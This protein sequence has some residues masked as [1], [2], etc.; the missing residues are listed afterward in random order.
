M[1]APTSSRKASL[2]AAGLLASASLLT[3]HLE[4]CDGIFLEC[5]GPNIFISQGAD[6]RPLQIC[7]DP[8]LLTLEHFV[9]SYSDAVAALPAE[10]L[11]PLGLLSLSSDVDSNSALLTQ[12]FTERM[13]ES[14]LSTC[15][16]DTDFTDSREK[17]NPTNI[18]Y[19]FYCVL[20]LTDPS[21]LSGETR[22]AA[23]APSDTDHSFNL[24]HS[25]LHRLEASDPITAVW[26]SCQ[27]LYSRC[28]FM[29]DVDQDGSPL[30]TDCD[31]RDATR[32]PEA[33]ELCNGL[34]EDCNDLVPPE[35]LDTD[36]DGLTSCAGDCDDSNSQI[37]PTAEDICDGMDNDCSGDADEGLDVR[38]SANQQ[39]S[40]AGNREICKGGEGWQ[41]LEGNYE[42]I[43]ESCND[44]DD[45][46]AEGVDDG[47][48][49]IPDDLLLGECANNTQYCAG[50]LGYQPSPTNY[51]P[52]FE[53]CNGLDDDC[54]DLV[55]LNELDDDG[56]GEQPCAGD[57]DDLEALVNSF[58]A[59]ICDA[60]DNDCD[61]EEDDGMEPVLS[62]NQQGLCS[63]NMD[64]CTGPSGYQPASSNYL[65]QPEVCDG[66]DNNCDGLVDEG[67][68]EIPDLNILGE[69]ANNTLYCAG[70]LGYQPSATNVVLQ[71]ETC[72][73]LDTNCDGDIDEG[74]GEIPDLNLFGRCANNTL[75][76]AGTLGYQPSP[77]NWTPITE[78]C[79][80]LDDDCDGVVPSD[81]PDA[82]GDSQAACDGDCDD[83]DASR[84]S[85]YVEICD[86]ID[87]DCDTL[88]D[89]GM[90]PQPALNIEGL[91]TGNQLI[92]QG[93]SG[94]VTDP[95]NYSPVSE[96]C[97]GFDNDCTGGVDD[98]LFLLPASNTLG[99]C[100]NNSQY[101]DPTLGQYM[102]SPTNYVPLSSELCNG[103]D[104]T[105]S[106]SLLDDELDQ[107]GDTE[108]PCAG[109]CDDLEALVNSFTA[110]I[111]DAL[112]N[113]CNDVVDDSLPE[114]AAPN[115][116][117][118][119]AVNTQYCDDTTLGEYVDSLD[120]Y[121][122]IS[123][124]CNALDDDCNDAIDENLPEIPASN[125]LGLCIDNVQYCDDTTSGQYVDSPT[126]YL[127]SIETCDGLD[128]DCNGTIDDTVD[129][130]LDGQSPCA[131]D[132]DDTDPLIYS[133]LGA[134]DYCNTGLDEDCDGTIDN[135]C[136][137]EGITSA[138]GGEM[139]AIPSLEMCIGRF[140]ASI[141]T[142]GE[143]EQEPTLL[144]ATDLTQI[145]YAAACAT[146]GLVLPSEALLFAA[147]GG[148]DN[149]VYPYGD[150]YQAGVCDDAQPQ[151]LPASFLGC[152]SP[153]GVYGLS[154]GVWELDSDCVY[155]DC[156]AHGGGYGPYTPA[157]PEQF[158]CTSARVHDGGGGDGNPA[159]T[160]SYHGFRCAVDMENVDP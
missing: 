55:P 150:I 65:V 134:T 93:S 75:Y 30:G 153:Y 89:N 51:I 34:D 48:S 115:T 70:T 24:L 106:G 53:Q 62:L 68:L 94:Y 58:T 85:L 61:Y 147:C 26:Q 3:P 157:N 10:T 71:E 112:D 13:E 142:N 16:Q 6:E 144:P 12:S 131:G 148:P 41:P 126:N 32:Y 7:P 50:A 11:D 156:D 132:C 111:C 110:E 60:L 145:A 18:G 154:G 140:E 22:D 31:D 143:A 121:I 84:S 20:P 138:Y 105:C 155:G 52:T 87:N 125:T 74:F 25:S 78:Q 5:G 49:E 139:V 124:I 107:D 86:G 104:D 38:D 141:N 158:M 45:D 15:P 72:D 137:P 40:C 36:D 63:G 117:G 116:Y 119:C 151:N 92:C 118:L 66:R 95:G 19:F 81:E 64:I 82:D 128:N 114:V 39:G 98:N 2:R 109:D 133:G 29:P 135:N 80:L 69:C 96:S 43:S 23:Y 44:L 113:D 76:C 28:T 35:E 90:V 103:L 99:L 59:E 73:G 47:L 146:R 129:I 160:S 123:E 77:T 88:V 102:D 97:D 8:D 27:E 152:V 127:P 159:W 33:V 122:P 9:Q 79:N 42:P 101:C 91:C 83:S 14:I 67:L 120:N 4:S 46:C 149:L 54:N 136:C 57:C 108:M 17:S 100:A 130:D 56:D 21:Y 1:T 37:N